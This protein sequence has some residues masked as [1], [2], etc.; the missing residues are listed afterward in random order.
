MERRNKLPNKDESLVWDAVEFIYGSGV[1]EMGA[2]ALPFLSSYHRLPCRL[3]SMV[4]H[5]ASCGHKPNIPKLT[6]IRLWISSPSSLTLLAAQLKAE[7]PLWVIL[8]LSLVP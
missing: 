6:Y 5:W 1:H 3:R 8:P 4:C 2:G 7:R